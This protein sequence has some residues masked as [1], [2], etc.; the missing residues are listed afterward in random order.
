M[1]KEE[2][3]KNLME[4]TEE[5]STSRSLDSKETDSSILVLLAKNG[6]VDIRLSLV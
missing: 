3:L 1:N 2:L 5:G 4:G 6:T